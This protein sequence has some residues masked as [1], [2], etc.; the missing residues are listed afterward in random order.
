MKECF[1]CEATQ[2]LHEHH[3]V[4]KSRGGTKTVTLCHQC[5]MKA[6]GRDGKGLNHRK[7]TK[8]GM[9]TALEKRRLIDPNYKF[10]NPQIEIAQK[11][12]ILIRQKIADEKA[13]EYFNLVSS[14][15]SQTGSYRATARE[16]NN[17]GI[18]TQRNKIWHASTVSNIIKRMEKVQ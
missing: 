5:H 15:Y 11:N 6:H 17:L 9:K 3:V 13:L 1:E 7:L 4:P 14:L 16:L 18:K 2:D 8:E 10:G 12:S